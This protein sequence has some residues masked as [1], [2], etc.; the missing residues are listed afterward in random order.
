MA[1]KSPVVVEKGTIDDIPTPELFLWERD[2]DYPP[3][4]GSRP[5]QK[6]IVVPRARDREK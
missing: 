5:A 2:R 4:P 1:Q 6:L 3:Q